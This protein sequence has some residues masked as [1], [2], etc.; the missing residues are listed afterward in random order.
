[1]DERLEKLIDTYLPMSE[2]S[3]LL[4]LSLLTPAHGYKIMQTIS[5]KSNGRIIM[6]PSTVYTLLYKMEQDGLIRVSSEVER[7]KIYEITDFGIG[8]LLAENRRLKLLI[9]SSDEL[10]GNMKKNKQFV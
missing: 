4:L 2:Q 7:R 5:E 1:M 6:G 3:F 10:L 8:V 9:A